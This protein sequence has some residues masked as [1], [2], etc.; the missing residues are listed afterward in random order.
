MANHFLMHSSI[1][2]FYYFCAYMERFRKDTITYLEGK[3]LKPLTQFPLDLNNHHTP[4]YEVVKYKSR[5]FLFQKHVERLIHSVRKKGYK[6]LMEIIPFEKD[7]LRLFD[8]NKCMEGNVR[9]DYFPDLNLCISYLIPY[10]YPPPEL[11]HQGVELCFQFDERPHQSIKEYHSELKGRTQKLIQEKGVFET[12]LVN[13]RSKIT[14]GSR[15]NVFFIKHDTVYTSPTEIVLPG[16]TRAAMI[17]FLY[18]KKIK[19]VENLISITDLQSFDSAFITGTSIG[20]LPVSKIETHQLSIKNPLLQKI[21]K[22]FNNF[23]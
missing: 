8:H 21:V 6:P 23:Q 22:G 10:F 15:S 3:I 2:P 11:Y 17:D 4:V 12:L 5:L 20:A 13:S 1:M 18:R 9:I 19:L 14:E 7:I 16:I